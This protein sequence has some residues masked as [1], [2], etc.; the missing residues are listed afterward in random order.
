MPRNCLHRQST[1]LH[2]PLIH[3]QHLMEQE[4]IPFEVNELDTHSSFSMQIECQT[5]R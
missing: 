2:S 5:N 4:L 3:H 1:L